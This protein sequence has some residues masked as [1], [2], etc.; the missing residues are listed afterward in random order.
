M[1][2]GVSTGC[3]GSAGS[4]AGITIVEGALAATGAGA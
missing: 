1:V 2:G 4:V 3:C